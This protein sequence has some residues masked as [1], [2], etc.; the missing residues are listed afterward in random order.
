MESYRKAGVNFLNLNVGFGDMES[1]EIFSILEMIRGFINDN[2]DKYSLVKSLDDI[3]NC[4]NSDKLAIAF[5]LEGV[6]AIDGNISLL[7]EYYQQGVRQLLLCYNKNNIA[8]SGC[9]DNDIGLTDFGKAVVKHMNVLGMVV[10]C[11]HTGFQT[12][13]DIMETSTQPVIFSHS[14]PY[15]LAKHPRNISDTQIK[16][17]ASLGGVI[18]I[19][20]I[21]IF[22]GEKIPSAQRMVENIDYIAQ[23]VG[24]MHAGIGLDYGF[25]PAEMVRLAKANPSLFPPQHGFDEVLI[26]HPKYIPDIANGLI[27]RGYKDQD[28][29]GIMGENFLRIVKQV[30]KS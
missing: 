13:L 19:N 18:G 6:N 11:S 8:G 21:S 2:E 25:G 23:L 10:D 28:I 26:L 17:C 3:E 1:L 12:T 29:A 24:P 7:D 5:D 15:S 16:L 14:N 27:A 22:L 4:I 30:W 9:M 20:G